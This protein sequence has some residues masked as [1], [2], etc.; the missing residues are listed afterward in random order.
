MKRVIGHTAVLC[1]WALLVGVCQAQAPAGFGQGA[2]RPGISPYLNLARGGNP[3]INYYGLVRPQIAAAQAF[4]TL[5]SNIV[6]LETSIA[7]QPVQTG[8]R[9]SFM[10]HKGYFMNNGSGAARTQ[11]PSASGAPAVAPPRSGR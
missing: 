9:A 10:T 1:C 4:Q 3:A 6:D 2:G 5:G 7:N 8:V 11:A